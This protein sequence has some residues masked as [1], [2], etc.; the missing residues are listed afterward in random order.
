MTKGSVHQEGITI[1]SVDTLSKHSF[2]I[3]E[4]K[5][6][7]TSKREIDTSTVAVRSFNTPLLIID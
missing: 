7:E 6:D 3:H 1:L 4:A 5:P 2:E